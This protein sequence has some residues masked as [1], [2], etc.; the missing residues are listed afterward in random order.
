MCLLFRKRIRW[1]FRSLFLTGPLSLI[2]LIYSVPVFSQALKQEFPVHISVVVSPPYSKNIDA[3]ISQPDKVMATFLSNAPA[4]VDVYILGVFE[5]ENGIRVYTDPGYKMY[6]PVT[7]L[8]GVPY[9]L[10]RFNLEQVFDS[11]NLVCQGITLSELIHGQGLPEDNYTIC[12]QAFDYLTGETVSSES[13]LGCSNPFTVSDLEPPVILFPVSGQD[14]F[15]GDFQ[16]INFV[17][18]WPPGAPN[19]TRFALKI[20]EVLPADRN[21][22]DAFRSATQPVFFEKIIVSTN[23]LYGPSDPRLV[24]G[25]TYAFSITASDPLQKSFFR[26]NGESEIASFNFLPE[27]K[28]VPASPIE[29]DVVANRII[30]YNVNS[31]TLSEDGA[32]VSGQ[33]TVKLDFRGNGDIIFQ[34]DEKGE[35]QTIAC[36]MTPSG[37]LTWDYERGMIPVPVLVSLSALKDPTSLIETG[38]TWSKISVTDGDMNR[39]IEELILNFK[40]EFEALPVFQTGEEE[41]ICIQTEVYNRIEPTDYSI[42]FYKNPNVTDGPFSW[43]KYLSGTVHFNTHLKCLERA[44]MILL[45]V[46]KDQ[47]PKSFKMERRVQNENKPDKN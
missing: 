47:A 29:W 21:I 18:T 30:Y 2:W 8:P 36:K 45:P 31:D 13:P 24:P 34:T 22:N 43:E 40:G 32:P 20:I 39:N 10:N 6:P 7:L 26:N 42:N 27:E 15:A 37:N 9:Y 16:N 41:L 33:Y 4:P 25:K 12:L 28:P 5:G 3:Y 14:I 17:W 1:L 46:F 44:E 38:D 19:S 35:P 23:Y 11:E